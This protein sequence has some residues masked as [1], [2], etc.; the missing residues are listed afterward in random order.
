MYDFHMTACPSGY[1]L[2]LM[3]L[4]DRAVAFLESIGFYNAVIEAIEMP[5]SVINSIR[6]AGFVIRG[7]V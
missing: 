3:P 1:G 2:R 4:N 6:R 5:W 7:V